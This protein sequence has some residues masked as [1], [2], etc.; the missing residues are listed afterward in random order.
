VIEESNEEDEED[1]EGLTREDERFL[2][3]IRNVGR[4][5]F[6]NA[7]LVM[8]MFLDHERRSVQGGDV[9]NSGVKSYSDPGRPKIVS[10]PFIVKTYS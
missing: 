9:C 5:R 2:R 3:R 4:W 7:A 10:G 8:R 1:E 6:V